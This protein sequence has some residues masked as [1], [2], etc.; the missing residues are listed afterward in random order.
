[1]EDI[2][3]Q[4]RI[5]LFNGD[6][7][8]KT[9]SGD[10][11][12]AHFVMSDGPHGL[13][14]QD[15]EHYADINESKIAT[16]FPTASCSAASWDRDLIA[17]MARCLALEALQEKVDVVLGCGINIKRSPLCGRNFEYISEDPYLTGELAAS[18]INGVQKEGVGT[19]LK[20]FACNNQETRRQTCNSIVDE[21]T[22]AEIYLRGFEKAVRQ[23]QPFT[24]MSSYNRVNGEYVG[25][26]K[27]FLDENLRKKW[28]FE[29]AVIS[30]WGACIGA[31]QCVEAGMDLAMPDSSGYLEKCLERSFEKG[32]VSEEALAR[33]NDRILSLAEKVSAKRRDFVVNYNAHHDMSRRVAESSAVL[34]KNDGILPLAPQ[35]VCVIGELA[36]F[37]KFQGGGS[38]HITT[39]KFPNAIEALKSSGFDVE[40][41]KGYFEGF[42]KKSKVNKI[43][44]PLC[45]EALSVVKKITDESNGNVPV[46]FFCGLTESYEGEGFDR[47]SLDLPLEQQELLAKI[48]EITQNVVLVSFSGAPIIFPYRDKV[49]AILHMYLC[50]EG[51]GEAVANLVSGKVNPSGKLAETFPLKIEDT[52]CYG[53]FALEG[54]NIE[55]REQVLV[56]YRYYDTL[57]VPVEYEFGYGLSYTTFDYE[58]LEFDPEKECFYVTVRNSGSR[59]GAEIV[60]LYVVNPEWSDGRDGRAVRARKELRGFG[61]IFLKAGETGV[62]KIPL[63][64]NACSVYSVKSGKFEVVEGNYTVEVC[65]SISNVKLSIN[66]NAQADDGEATNHFRDVVSPV[67]DSFYG[68]HSIVPHKKGEFT[69]SDSFGDMAK[70]SFSVRFVLG[71]FEK[72]MVMSSKSKS[73]EDPAVK[74]GLSGLRENPAESLISTGGGA[75]S[76]KLVRWLVKKANR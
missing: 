59:D 57:A 43:N 55:Y 46:L 5:R 29:G 12:F 39:A 9:F 64:E 75:V 63:D 15:E 40:Y 37:M 49:K 61:K 44:R 24:I 36:E 67:E 69:V 71:I 22:L 73:R 32:E 3:L 25:A 50:G 62:V 19:S 53:N 13:R 70:K 45:K 26:S 6:G 72:L 31:A 20:H 7:S 56:G 47:V 33:A 74:I 35:K 16:C 8:W 41:S 76:E 11:R 54:D 38:S 21:R 68:S 58:N 10:G 17:E 1:M 48:L 4:D 14:K 60:Q 52:P 65:S 34:L 2:S 18:Y 28:G 23:A 42:C 30:D 27:F 51:A 66:I